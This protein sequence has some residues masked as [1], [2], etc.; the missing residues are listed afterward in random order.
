MNIFQITKDMNPEVVSANL[1]PSLNFIYSPCVT[2]DE[3]I[4]TCQEADIIISIY[5]PM[6]K[7]VLRALPKL[8]YVALGSIGYNYID[9]DCGRE[10]GIDISNNPVY[11]IEEV[12]DHTIG[13]MIDRI[14]HISDFRQSVQGEEVWDFNIMG[15]SLMRMSNLTIGLIG[16][17][18][19]SRQV[20]KRLKGFGSEILAYDPY[21]S[22]EEMESLEVEKVELAEIQERADVI[23][24]HL[25]L[26]EETYH[27]ID[28]DFLKALK[29]SPILINVSRGQVLDQSVL[30]EAL[31]RS[32]IS[33]LALDVL[34]KEFPEPDLDSIDFLKDPRVILTP[35]VAFYSQS[36]ILEAD[37]T[38]A[39]YI[40][41]YICGNQEEIPFVI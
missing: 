35:H 27:M 39:K 2:E 9:V 25:P 36:S 4:Q 14:R 34:E 37:K 26:V 38:V 17:G 1:D 15:N 41:N 40:N 13:L 24:L 12:A 10:L 11:C 23:S 32:W 28:R 29:R 21:L 20:A 16:F 18:R 7:R 31:D 33:G 5:E 22:S 8:K 3:I 6:T 30:K 19:I